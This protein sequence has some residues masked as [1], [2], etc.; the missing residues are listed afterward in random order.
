MMRARESQLKGSVMR[1][2]EPW[3]VRPNSEFSG[4]NRKPQTSRSTEG[5]RALGINHWDFT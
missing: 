1:G 3:L 2:G 4:E 5:S